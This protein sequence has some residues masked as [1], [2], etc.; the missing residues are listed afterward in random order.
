MPADI[1]TTTPD[2]KAGLVLVPQA[3]R[4]AALV[5]GIF[6]LILGLAMFFTHIGTR[7]EDPLKSPQ[8]KQLKESLR[9]NP[10]DEQ[11][12]T[13]IRLLDLQLRQTYF[14]QISRMKIGVYML[15]GGVAVFLISLRQT[16]VKHAFLPNLLQP[17][18]DLAEQHSRAAAIARWSVGG[19]AVL[20]AGGL[21]LIAATGPNPLPAKPAEID[22][23][24]GVAAEP[25]AENPVSAEE[26][27]RNWA[28]F[29]GS[30]GNGFAAACSNSPVKWD[31]KSGEGV[32]WRIPTPVQGFNSPIVW[33][34]RVFFSGGDA[35][36][37]EVICLDASTGQTLWRREVANVPGSPAIPP[38]V[39]ESTGYAAPT[40]ACD[41]HR[42]YVIFANGD[43]ASFT[44][45]GKPVWSK[46]FGP[47]KNPYGHANS[48]ATW[49]SNL[50]L[51]LDQGESEDG[52]SRLVS[53]DGR[54][55]QPVWQKP[56]KA[57]ASWSSP[58][59]FEAGGKAQVVL[60]S[61][62]FASGYAVNDGAE[63]WKVDCL[64][65]E[66]TPS[67]IFANG[68]V[69]VLSPSDK[70]IAIRPDGQGDVTKT[71]VAWTNEDSI[72]DITSP[73]S[74]GDLLFMLSTSGMLTCLDAKNGKKIWEHDF[75]IECHASP[76]IA[77]G[78]VYMFSQKG[79]A[80][81]FEAA[82]GYKELFRTEMGDAF[83]ASPAFVDDRIYLRGLT[84]VWCL[85]GGKG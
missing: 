79:T 26:F 33:G 85:G 56:R 38:E 46:S 21:G 66:V 41:G 67:P 4:R 13:R 61:I 44:F 35:K 55:G 36:K 30:D 63:L 52:K 53:L 80:V 32:A 31:V 59:V 28:R 51:Q 78:R 14:R 65:G 49:K 22:K 8:L 45:E 19:V 5:S 64:N 76:T 40:M 62:P 43:V 84:N 11:I 37:R 57:G 25:V 75:E 47:L 60:L 34:K 1:Q 81:V 12:K 6:S 54:T 17:K 71:H 18:T 16:S 3:W 69:F 74:N 50:I 68:L 83:H 29:L 27:R 24:L 23:F 2:S 72:P 15:L 42:V 48:L 58:T 73:A 82:R 77:G 10:A 7:A 9:Q 70:A 39:P 20:V